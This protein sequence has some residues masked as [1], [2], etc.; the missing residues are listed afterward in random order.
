MAC[1]DAGDW[2]IETAFSFSIRFIGYWNSKRESKL[3]A[4]AAEDRGRSAEDAAE[5]E[6]EEHL[7]CIFAH[8]DE[9]AHRLS[10]IL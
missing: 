3:A 8:R 6:E 7:F 10:E 1:E 5:W 2:R 9:R 4:S